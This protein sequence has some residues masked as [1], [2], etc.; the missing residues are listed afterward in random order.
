MKISIKRNI[1]FL[2]LLLTLINSIKAQY[3]TYAPVADRLQAATY[4]GF[5][6]SNGPYYNQTNT[7]NTN[8][9]YWWN[10]HGVDALLDGYLRTRSD[11]YKTR[12]KSLL[13]GIKVKNGGLYPTHFYDDMA[14]LALASLRSYEIIGDSE[15]L[16]AA[17]T[18]WTDMKNGQ[19]ADL[20]GAIQWNKS[21]PNSMNA[22]TNGP[23]IILATRLYRVKGNAADLETA[24]NIYTWMK[25]MLVN[26]VTGEVWDNYDAGTKVTNKSWIFSY[27]QGTWIGACFELYKITGEQTYL[28]EALKTANTA[29]KNQVGGILYPNSGGGDGGLFHGI[30]VRYLTQLARESNIPQATKN[31]YINV[32]KSSAQALKNYGINSKNN[33]ANSKWG[34]A[35]GETTD[36]SNQLS[37]TMLI[38]AAST[39]DLAAVYANNT[40]GGK[41]SYLA[42]GN[43]NLTQLVV[44]GISNDNISSLTLP[45]GLQLIAFADDNFGG[46]S[47]V[48]SSNQAQL[49]EWDNKISSLKIRTIGTGNGLKGEYFAGASLETLK[50]TQTD[51]VIN[52]DWAES[53]PKEASLGVDNFSIRWSGFIQALNSGQYTFYVSGDDGV[54]LTINKVVLFDSFSATGQNSFS[55]TITLEAGQKYDITLEY[56]EKSGNASC[57]LEWENQYLTRQLVP[58]TQL[59]TRAVSSLDI[60]MAY[61]DCEYKG[62]YAGLKVGE[63]TLAELNNLGVLNKDIAS[64]K[65]PQGYKVTLFEEDNFNGNSIE[66]IKD[67]SCLADWTDKTSSLIVTTNGLT[68][69]EG[70]YYLKNRTSNYNLA[71]EGTYTNTSDGANVLINAMSTTLNQQFKLTHMGN[72][73]YTIR[74]RHSNKPI[75]VASYSKSEAANVQQMT[76]LGADNQY[77][78]LV[79]TPDGYYKFIAK[80]SGKIIEAASTIVLANVR[81]ASNLNQ[82]K[83]QWQITPVPAYENAGGTGLDAAYYNGTEFNTFRFNRVDTTINFNWGTGTPDSRISAENFSVRWTGKIQPR[84]GG[85][86]TFY[87]NSDNGRRLWINNQLVIDKWLNDYDV[88]YSGSI[89]LAANQMYDFKMEYFETTGGANCK[90]EW[91]GASQAREVVPKSQLF[92]LNT[93]IDNPEVAASDIEIYPNPITNKMM[94][95]SVK[96]NAEPFTVKL[97][98]MLGNQVFVSENINSGNVNLSEIPKG[99]Y[100]VSIQNKTINQNKR[101]VIQ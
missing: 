74:A 40:Y 97:Y 86:Y 15:Y 83:G 56:S 76:P 101:I 1:T 35:P 8:F 88:E 4:S 80:H 93:A 24:K 36:Y 41:L 3:S 65:I 77:F 5:Y 87:I 10:A 30:F 6:N 69:M 94:H 29:I 38:E 98:N 62:F 68:N 71:V 28:N 44:K 89:N 13:L 20:G 64:L 33:T 48:F 66:L 72:G 59:Y 23:A 73:T 91:F 11:V 49:T 90:L 45:A 63:Y 100:V 43:Y 42:L 55:N 39:F 54:K 18:L 57:K 9:N 82:T 12:M 52:F 34:V 95:I 2:V 92:P 26:P 31:N 81:Q 50:F 58:V 79:E 85:T 99:M 60:I 96:N 84:F 67:S 47:I 78:I 14:W 46:D 25:S 21:A 70:I 75:E 27:N 37:A 22:C 51:E 7:G 53:S 17:N 61:A 16:T 19:H 32:L